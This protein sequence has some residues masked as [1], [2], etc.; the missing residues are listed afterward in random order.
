MRKL[1]I[2]SPTR[3]NICIFVTKRILGSPGYTFFS[4]TDFADLQL[5]INLTHF[6]GVVIMCID[7]PTKLYA[8]FCTLLRIFEA[9]LRAI[10]L[11]NF[12]LNL[13]SI[14][15]IHQKRHSSGFWKSSWRNYIYDYKNQE[16]FLFSPK[17][18]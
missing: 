7:A 9:V 3:R 16:T 12:S 11:Y 14:L 6:C 18:K 1:C 8:Q 5:F 4:I 2:P 10:C 15:H 17:K 13:Q